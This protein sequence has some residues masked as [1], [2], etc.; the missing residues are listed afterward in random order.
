MPSKL[1]KPRTIT[2]SKMGDSAIDRAVTLLATEL[3]L[4]A[5]DQMA[6][7]RALN[8]LFLAGTERQLH[9][10]YRTA[11]TRHVRDGELEV[12]SHATVSLSDDG[13]AYVQSWVWV[14]K[15]DVKDGNECVELSLKTSDNRTGTAYYVLHGGN[16]I[17]LGM[18]WDR[19]GDGET[20]RASFVVGGKE[21]FALDGEAWRENDSGGLVEM[22]VEKAFAQAQPNKRSN[23]TH[24]TPTA[25]G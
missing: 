12:D 19:D 4:S 17:G 11:A 25:H 2:S 5:D 23:Y 6:A 14:S 10:L 24:A 1:H 21:I 8:G 15:D 9:D 13:G 3:S 20:I 7:T 16:V 18:D 22:L